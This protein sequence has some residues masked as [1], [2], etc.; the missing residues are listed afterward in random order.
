MSTTASVSLPGPVALRA[1]ARAF[2]HFDDF[3]RFVGG[4][5]AALERSAVFAQSRIAL[6]RGLT[7]GA[8]R[9]AAGTLS[10]PLVGE[11]G[12]LGALQVG[13]P[14]ER[15]QFAAEDLHLLAGL[16]DFLSAV[17]AQAQKVQDAGRNRNLLRFLLNQAPIG[18]AAFTP[19]R[20]LLVA[21]DLASEWL[22]HAGPPFL[23]VEA[24]AK[25][26]H[27]RAA[28]KLIFGEARRAP[29]GVWVF[30]LHDLTPA[31]M[32]LM[33]TLQREVYRGLV[34]RRP[35]TLLLAES[36]AIQ[37]GVLRHLPALRQAMGAEGLV[38]PYDAQRLGVVLPGVGAVEGRRRLRDWAGV[39]Q[40]VEGLKVSWS[41]LGRDGTSPD[42][43]IEA[44]QRRAG[45][46]S[47]VA[48]AAVLL[49]EGDPGVADAIR[50][51]LRGEYRVV[52]SPSVGRTR[53]L[54]AREEFELLIAEMEPRE[55]PSGPEL[56]LAAREHQP[57][58][59]ALF[60]CVKPPPY[61]LPAALAAEGAPVLQKPF[62]PELLRSSVRERLIS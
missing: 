38:G 10:L 59:R 16:A 1:L 41:Q 17:L 33:E 30:A 36:S 6:D 39:W 31:Q 27:H 56:A 51:V 62:A 13:A 44:A 18:L 58:M 35:M 49:Q 37:N 29:D 4:L 48:K 53:E 26:F 52:H 19:D 24:G 55:G 34:E 21:N 8:G 54:L 43:L 61:E 40:E 5:Q 20:R 46:P 15:R 23:E 57:A 47:E 28:G 50:L 3:E 2:G 22:G 7:E 14:G 32:R 25:N 11:H 9:F 45:T 12:P 42:A 60:T